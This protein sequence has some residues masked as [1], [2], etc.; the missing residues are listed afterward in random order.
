M[1]KSMKRGKE[2]NKARWFLGFICLVAVLFRLGWIF[3]NDGKSVGGD[4]ELCLRPWFEEMK[5]G[6]GLAALGAYP[7]N[8]NA[9]YMTILA[10]LTYLPVDPGVSIRVVSYGFDFLLAGAAV[11]LAKELLKTKLMTEEK[12]DGTL[13]AVF[14]L[15]LFLPTVLFNSGVWCQCD[16]IYATFAI[17]ALV[18]LC[19]EKYV[20][21]VLL[22]GVALAFKLQAVFLLPVFGI[23]WFL[24]WGRK[25][26]KKFWLANFLWL[27]VPNIVLSMPAMICGMPLKKLVTVYLEQTENFGN[28][29]TMNFPNV[30][31]FLPDG[32]DEGLFC[33]VGVLVA[34]F[35]LFGVM[36]V[37]VRRGR[38]VTARFVVELAITTL[39]VAVA[40]LPGMHERY[41]YVGEVLI[42]IYVVVL[43]REYWAL[44]A[45]QVIFGM[46]YFYAF[47]KVAAVHYLLAAAFLTVVGAWTRRTLLRKSEG[48]RL[49]VRE[50]EKKGSRK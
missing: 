22:L 1:I 4:L 13:M 42:L 37:C 41:F 36:L 29:L 34:L 11:L 2:R 47:R 17:L 8:Y 50:L 23:V 45:T 5:A 30:Y 3:A 16:A 7:G 33:K 20:G 19:R 46:K 18:W 10:L 28:G 14:C 6:G 26:E 40:V 32:V 44:V 12:R 21:A 24:K 48:R 49:V 15:T 38:R 9:P 35:L 25:G 39:M 31:V 43:R 27:P